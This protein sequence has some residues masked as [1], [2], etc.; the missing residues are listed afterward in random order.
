MR[1]KG[2]G[3]LSMADAVRRLVAASEVLATYAI[4]VDARGESVVFYREFDFEP[5]PGRPSRLLRTPADAGAAVER[6]DE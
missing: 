5:I 4:L 3:A 2:V 6:A 1:G